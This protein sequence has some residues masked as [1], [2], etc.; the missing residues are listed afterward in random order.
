[1]SKTFKDCVC[2]SSMK[3]IMTNSQEAVT[4]AFTQKPSP[5]CK[6]CQRLKPRQRLESIN[7]LRLVLQEDLLYRLINHWLQALSTV[8]WSCYSA[9]TVAGPFSISHCM[10]PTMLSRTADIQQ[11]QYTFVVPCKSIYTVI[12]LSHLVILQAQA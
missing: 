11:F 8:V 10:A 7:F 5:T 2:E 3:K 1:M 4:V 9:T 12:N 6:L